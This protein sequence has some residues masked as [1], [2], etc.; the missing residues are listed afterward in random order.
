MPLESCILGCLALVLDL[1][2]YHAGAVSALASG[3]LRLWY[4]R[5]PFAT[6]F[7]PWE[8]GDG[9]AAGSITHARLR[10]VDPRVLVDHPLPEGVGDP[11]RVV[12]RRPTSKTPPGLMREREAGLPPK[13]RKGLFLP[14]LSSSSQEDSYFPQVGVG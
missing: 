2:G 11:S 13:R 9:S 7:S 1:L 12:W 4:C 10:E 8:L 5:N 14:G 6:R 3:A